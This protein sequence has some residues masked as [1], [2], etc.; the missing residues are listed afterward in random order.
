MLLKE[1]ERQNITEALIHLGVSS[2][3]SCLNDDIP[4]HILSEVDH[5]RHF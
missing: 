5:R 3:I 4:L 2:F 1:K